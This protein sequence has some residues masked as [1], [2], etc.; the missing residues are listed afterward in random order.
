[1]CVNC[2]EHFGDD[3]ELMPARYWNSI[4][5]EEPYL[6]VVYYTYNV[7]AGYDVYFCEKYASFK[8]GDFSFYGYYDYSDRAYPQW[9]YL[10]AEQIA[11]LNLP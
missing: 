2:Y 9:R 8:Q 3:P 1:M 6:G 10:S 4:S 5:Q 11:E 7:Y